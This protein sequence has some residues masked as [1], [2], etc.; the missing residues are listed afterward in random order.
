MLLQLL[1]PRLAL[2]L[3]V[4]YGESQ[5][6]KVGIGLGRQ[7]LV[8]GGAGGR[9]GGRVGFARVGNQL[10]EES[11]GQ[12]CGRGEGEEMRAGNRCNWEFGEVGR[13]EFRYQSRVLLTQMPV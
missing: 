1:S 8:S 9:G 12:V 13:R 10:V 7:A 6:F 3:K 2:R 5:R 4:G 11:R